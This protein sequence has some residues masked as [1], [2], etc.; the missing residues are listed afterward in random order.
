MII[1]LKKLQYPPLKAPAYNVWPIYISGG[2]MCQKA[3]ALPEHQ[4]LE[5]GKY[6]VEFL[7]ITVFVQIINFPLNLASFVTTIEKYCLYI[8]AF[9][10]NFPNFTSI[11][12]SPC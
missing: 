4:A 3:K 1:D 7:N 8:P 10:I 11:S 2:L 9:V 6:K 12:N 5:W